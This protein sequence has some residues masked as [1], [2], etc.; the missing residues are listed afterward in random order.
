[1]K[2]QRQIQQGFTLIELMIVVAI[3]GI[4]AAIAIPQYTQYTKKAKFTEIVNAT[5]PYKTAVELC[6]QD[7]ATLT[8]CDDNSNGIPD[9]IASGAGH[10][11]TLAVANGVITVT[12]A[13]YGGILATDTYILTP[14]YNAAAAATGGGNVT[15]ASSGGCKSTTGGAIC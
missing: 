13:A 5:Q 8:G 1:M 3:I 7:L 15:W 14:T 11:T 4:L 12:P 6:V 10:I 2:I 9:G